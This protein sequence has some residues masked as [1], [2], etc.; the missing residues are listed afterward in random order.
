[1]PMK[2]APACWRTLFSASTNAAY[3][4]NRRSPR[5]GEPRFMRWR[6]ASIVLSHVV[7]CVSK[8][9]RTCRKRCRHADEH[10]FPH[11]RPPPPMLAVLV[12]S[13]GDRRRTC[14]QSLRFPLAPPAAHAGSPR[15]FP[16]RPP[17]PMLA[18]LALSLG[19]P[20][21]PAQALG[22][23]KAVQAKTP[24]PPVVS[25]ASCAYSAVC[26]RQ[27]WRRGAGADSFSRGITRARPAALGERAGG[28]AAATGRGCGA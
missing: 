5:V 28:L 19:H 15:V 18:V 3:A 25:L 23:G 7:F 27:G 10:R 6:V 12:F 14:R 1:M 21:R 24:P 11:R 2:A 8:R 13:L 4:N 17:P 22:P 9:C 20:R 26:L 16:W